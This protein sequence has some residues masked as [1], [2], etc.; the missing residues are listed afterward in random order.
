MLR[1]LAQGLSNAEIAE[2]LVVGSHTVNQPL[3]SIY[4]KLNVSSRHAG[5]HHLLT[6]EG[7]TFDAE[8]CCSGRLQVRATVDLLD[9][10]HLAARSEQDMFDLQ[11]RVTQRAYHGTFTGTRVAP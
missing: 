3:T 4:A 7:Y 5:S 8:G 2:R 6:F 10:D 11:G 1:L 9:D